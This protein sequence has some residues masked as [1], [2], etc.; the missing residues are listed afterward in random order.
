M[1]QF[2]KQWITA[3]CAP[4]SIASVRSDEKGHLDIVTNE[5]R[6]IYVYVLSTDKEVISCGTTYE[7]LLVPNQMN[8]G[9]AV[10]KCAELL[11]IHCL[12]ISH[13]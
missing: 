12:T 6:T 5:K 8:Y 4:E 2:T 10:R 3:T 13:L 11:Q 7:Q 1:N 9:Q